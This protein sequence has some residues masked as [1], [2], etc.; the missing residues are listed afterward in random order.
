METGHLAQK[1]L[2]TLALEV[3]ECLAKRNGKVFIDYNTVSRTGPFFNS[4]TA[5]VSALHYGTDASTKLLTLP[6]AGSRH[7]TN[8]PLTDRGSF[9]YYWISTENG[10]NA[11]NLYFKSDTVDPTDLTF[12]TFGFSVRCI[13]E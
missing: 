11:Y 6:A 2:K 3:L 10:S 9:C 4:A 8:G 12:R 13:A 1:V 5:Y 7:Q